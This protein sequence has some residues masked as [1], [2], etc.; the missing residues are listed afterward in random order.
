MKRF[1]ISMI[2]VF[3]LILGIAASAF[4]TNRQTSQKTGKLTI[5]WFQF[6]GSDPTDLTQV[7]DN[8]NYSYQT[9][10]P[11]SGS[12]HICA[13]QTDGV[14]SVG[15]QPAEFSQELKDEL[16]DVVNNGASYSDISKKP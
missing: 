12:N 8:T 9:G 14:A 15:E 16:A 13:V 11:C 3:A 1:K 2:A 5:T 10:L 4:T 6:M 7:Q